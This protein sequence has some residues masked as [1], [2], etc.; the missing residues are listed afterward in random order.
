[1]WVRKQP[2]CALAF[3]SLA[4]AACSDTPTSLP[5]DRTAAAP[6]AE[7]K[8]VVPDR[9]VVVFKD[10]VADAPGLARQLTQ[11]HGGKLHHSY[12]RAL[13]GF[14]ATLP[15][16]AVEALRR[17]PNVAYVQPD[18]RAQAVQ[19]GSWGLDRIDQ[20]DLPLDGA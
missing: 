15:A 9:Y 7:L 8:A 12:R 10:N 4:L 2:V 3:L 19:V 17:N 16:P 14:A 20:R 13:K 5:P 1:M 6:P 18:G 11:A